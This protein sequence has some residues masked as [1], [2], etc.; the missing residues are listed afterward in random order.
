MGRLIISDPGTAPPH[1]LRMFITHRTSYHFP[2]G[3][4][5]LLLLLR[6]W[7][8]PHAGQVVR[9]WS[10]SVND[11]PVLPS[12]RSGHG[13][14]VALWSA[15]AYPGEIA[16][17]ATGTVEA[18]DKAGLVAGLTV[19]PNPAIFLRPT[20]RTRADKAIRELMPAP[21]A[22]GATIAWLH[23]LMRAVHERLLYVTGS[24]TVHTSAIEALKDG[25]GVCQ[26]HSHLFIAAARAHGVPA[27]YVCGYLLADGDHGDLHETHAWA[28][29]WIEGMGWVAFDPSA[30]ICTTERYVRLTTGFDAL[31]AAPIRGH[32]TGGGALGVVA[33]VRISESVED[34][35][36]ETML[37]M[38]Q[39][40]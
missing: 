28:E 12:A 17:L 32:A 10:V 27:R 26:D 8:E 36:F 1:R 40:Q 7:P 5:R 19:R 25:A 33:D 24:T 4:A 20:M 2:A 29:A 39:Q 30:G 15:S 38:Q 3:A 31:D 11:E 23:D 35:G 34:G 16:I 37:Q 9:G 13:D 14:N 22:S 21:P 18:E 6:L